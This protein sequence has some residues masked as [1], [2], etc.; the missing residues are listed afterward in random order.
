VVGS[1]RNALSYKSLLSPGAIRTVAPTLLWTL[2]R[3]HRIGTRVGL[4]PPPCVALLSL[5]AVA[6][7]WHPSYGYYLNDLAMR[8][9][10]TKGPDWRLSYIV[11]FDA[12]RR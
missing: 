4:L 7:R 3:S 9:I 1:I 6:R 8:H 2:A 11:L 5:A 12:E 10:Y